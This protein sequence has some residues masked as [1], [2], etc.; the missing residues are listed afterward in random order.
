MSKLFSELTIAGVSFANR[1]WVSPMCQYS[2]ENGVA[3]E[4]HRAHYGAFSQ[5]GA[6]LVFVEAT[7]VAPIGRISVGCLGLWSDEHAQALAPI[8]KFA[9]ACGTKIGIQLAHAGRKG[10]TTRPWDGGTY[11]QSEGW[12]TVAPS[13]IAF[14]AF[15]APRA[16]EISELT[17]I[18]TQFVEAAVRAVELGFDVIEVHSAHGYLL[19]EFLSPITNKRTDEYGGSLENRMRLLLEVTSAVREVVPS[20]RALFVRISA[21][22]WAD[23]GF[24][25]PQSVEVA[26]ALKALGADFIDC[27]TGGLIPDAVIPV[28]PGYQVSFASDI[29]AQAQIPTSAVGAITTGAQA[30]KILTESGV[31]AV[32]IG[33]AMLGN[34]HWAVSAANELGEPIPWQKQ[35]VRGVIS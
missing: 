24:D 12:Q 18:K 15:P 28:G 2:A 3:N 10:A 22:D 30:E 26:K 17:E 11:S 14:G 23:G 32:M 29:E 20:D 13:E 33:R 25:G 8:V 35:Y 27:S 31:S 9:H 7:A 19:H 21:T 34:P 4:W 5:G 6:G 16:L 1:A